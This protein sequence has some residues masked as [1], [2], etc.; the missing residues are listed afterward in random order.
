M[1]KYRVQVIQTN[2]QKKYYPQYRKCFIWWSCEESKYIQYGLYVYKEIVKYKTL[3]EANDYIRTQ[4]DKE[5][6]TLGYINFEEE[7]KN[8]ILK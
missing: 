8:I 5:K 6:K 3:K 4:I 1:S 7:D 2:N